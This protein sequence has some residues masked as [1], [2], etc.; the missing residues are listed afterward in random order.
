MLKVYFDART[1][2]ARIWWTRDLP[3][4]DAEVG[5]V[6]LGQNGRRLRGQA[7][8]HFQNL[9]AAAARANVDAQN[10][11]A[12]LLGADV[13]EPRSSIHALD[14]FTRLVKEAGHA[15]LAVR[16]LFLRAFAHHGWV[17]DLD[18]PAR[19]HGRGKR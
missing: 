6:L 3:N 10:T 16:P 2:P 5:L 19:M 8:L 12:E 9:E 14:A 11:W 4:S 1:W 17:W 18:I 7:V 15:C 13:G